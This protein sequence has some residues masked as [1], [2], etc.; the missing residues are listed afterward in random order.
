MV[1]GGVANGANPSRRALLTTGFRRRGG[2][3]AQETTDG[4]ARPLLTG[5]LVTAAGAP[6]SGALLEVMRTTDRPGARMRLE[7]TARTDRRGRFEFRLKGGPSRR[8]TVRY[9][10]YSL[11]PEPSA[12][13]IANVRVRA[14][15]RLRVRPRRTTARGRIAFTG[16]LLGGPGRSGVQVALY[17]VDRGGRHRVPVS[18][19]TAD[20]RGGF[21]FAYRFLR[22]FAPFT[23]RFIARVEA[24][25]GYPYA[26][27]SSPVATVRIVR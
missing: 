15:V 1:N 26:A 7:G 17:A 11:D 5:R 8:L 20:R 16:W 25:A 23:Y 21:A 22:S 6:I 12:E 4:G 10:A 13:S 2:L 18:V 9:R 24:Q 19:L 27:G 3:R 14:R